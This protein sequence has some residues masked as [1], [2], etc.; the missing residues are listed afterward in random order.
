MADRIMTAMVGV[1]VAAVVARYLGPADFGRIAYAYSIAAMFAIIGQLGLDGLLVRELKTRPGSAETTLGT[2]VAMKVVAYAVA[3]LLLMVFAYSVPVHDATDYALFAITACFVFLSSFGT[4]NA[5]FHARV[6]GRTISLIGI[7]AA[8]V[9]AAIKIFLVWMEAGVILIGSANLVPVMVSALLLVVVYQRSGGP[10]ILSWRFSPE[11]ARRLMA[12][13]WMVLLGS[14]LALIYLK[15]DLAMLRWLSDVKSV[16]EYAVAAQLSEATYFIPVAI[17]TSTFPRILELSITDRKIYEARLQQLMDFLL[18][19]ALAVV[20][21]TYLLGGPI[22]TLMFGASYSPSIEILL[23]HVLAAPFIYM[24]NVF[25][26]WILVERVAIFSVITQGSGA[27]L[28][29]AL[30]LILIPQM[31]GKGAAI[32]TVISYVVASYLSL[33]ISPRTRPVFIMMSRS[34][35]PWQAMRRLLAK[36]EKNA[37]T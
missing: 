36:P 1:I 18:L 23:I 14:M 6:Q 31:G 5:W 10:S 26:R 30:N 27:L 22:I 3:S 25:S 33:A 2:V 28:N 19:T 9:A 37:R 16:G 11:Y 21:G 17:V 35:V 7:S 4:L 32:A 20:A 29:V 8:M 13:G 12:E 15:I 24:R 34:L